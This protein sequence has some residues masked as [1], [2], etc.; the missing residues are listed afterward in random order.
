MNER[1]LSL[2]FNWQ[3]DQVIIH[4]VIHFPANRRLQRYRSIEGT[5]YNAVSVITMIEKVGTKFRDGTYVG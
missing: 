4:F 1:S 3:N 5:R 2:N